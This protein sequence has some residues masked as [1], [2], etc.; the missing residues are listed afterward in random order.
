MRTVLSWGSVARRSRLYKRLC[1]IIRQKSVRSS[2]RKAVQLWL[3]CVDQSRRNSHAGLRIISILNRARLVTAMESFTLHYWQRKKTR[4]KSTRSALARAFTAL[5]L[6]SE[7]FQRDERHSYEVRFHRAQ[8][9]FLPSSSA[10]S[11][12]SRSLRMWMGRNA[13]KMQQQTCVNAFAH[14]HACK[15]AAHRRFVQ[16]NRFQCR[17]LGYHSSALLHSWLR[18]ASRKMTLRQ[19]CRVIMQHGQ[20][21]MCSLAFETWA[22][23]ARSS[24][25]L[26]ASRCIVGRLVELSQK[27]AF[28]AWQLVWTHHK[29]LDDMV[30]IEAAK[31]RDKERRLVSVIIQIG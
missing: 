30:A 16:I 29:E 1:T 19:A 17:W 8:P 6:L 9:A 23:M 13:L 12:F 11:K 14:W 28:G 25:R 7:T 20:R 22:A 2:L 3:Q 10:E 26:Q 24:R 18:A 21:S 31:V 4:A 15:Q 5:R 27:A